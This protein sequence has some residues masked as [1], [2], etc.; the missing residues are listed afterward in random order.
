LTALSDEF[1]EF[2][3]KMGWSA[4]VYQ[5]GM[6]WSDAIG[7]ANESTPMTTSTPMAIMSTSK[8]FLSA[9]I[10][11][12]VEDGLY[13]LDD[14]ISVLLAD[15]NG[16]QSVNKSLIPDAS[17]E[18]HLRMASGVQ[19]LSTTSVEAYLQSLD[20]NWKPSGALTL[21]S[22]PPIPPGTYNYTAT[23]SFLLGLVAEHKGGDDLHT[24]YRTEFF[25]PLSLKAGLLP[26]IQTPTNMSSTYADLTNYGGDPGWGNVQDVVLYRDFDFWEAEGRRNWACCGVVSTPESIARWG[27]ELFSPNGSAVS[28]NVRQQLIDSFRDLTEKAGGPWLY[29]MHVAMKEQRLSDGTVIQ[30]YG[31]PGGGSGATSDLFYVPLLDLAIALQANTEDIFQRATCVSPGGLYSDEPWLSPSDCVAREIINAVNDQ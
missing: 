20:P 9:L 3:Q 5:K 23:S 10:L 6:L 7:L 30:T 14:L 11:S 8:T 27:Y 18:Q 22:G 13:A 19:E 31:H 2:D 26:H 21:V 4:A 12:Q 24:L 17:V 15:H 16:Y 28:A 1:E 29:G 25:E